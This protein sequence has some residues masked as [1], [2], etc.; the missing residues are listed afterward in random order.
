M[1]AFLQGA[2]GERAGDAGKGGGGR[3][4]KLKGREE[5]DECENKHLTEHEDFKRVRETM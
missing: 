1:V 5:S 3:E 4:W 2:P